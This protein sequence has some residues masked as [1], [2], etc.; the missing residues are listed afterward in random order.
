MV[1][2]CVGDRPWVVEG[3]GHDR[4]NLT[5]PGV[6]AQ[7]VCTCAGMCRHRKIEWKDKTSGVE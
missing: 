3:E 7:M 2:F 5:L 4:F 6:Q 1:V